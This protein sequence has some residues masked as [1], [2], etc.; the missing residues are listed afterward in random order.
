V[1][2]A[3]RAA[4][5]AALAPPSRWRGLL[6][7]HTAMPAFLAATLFGTY[8]WVHSLAL[9]DIER[10]SLNTDILLRL[11]GQHLKLTAVTT[12]TVVVVA[13]GAGIL[14]TRARLR[15]LAPVAT[16]LANIG[17]ATPAIGLLVLLSI[18]LGI[19]FTT[20]LIGLV[21]YAVLPVLR[22]T[23][24]GINQVDP[25]L[26]EAGKGI[27]MSPL[28]VLTRVELPLALPVILA[29]VRTALV[30]AVGV[31]TLATFINAGGLGGLIV[32][33]IKLQRTPVLVTGAVL[34]GALAL[35]LDWLGG[36]I[37]ELFQPRGLG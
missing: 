22:N 36:V 37:A 19:G 24:V 21:A 17:Q 2:S 6:G 23:I 15:W 7:R 16:G 10:R 8:L 18:W 4:G 5:P 9:D 11:V 29:G 12:V 35:V 27:G 31:A 20:A 32:T 28:A 25:H 33:G 34:T 13:V 30:L 1:T 26:I 3:P 14:L